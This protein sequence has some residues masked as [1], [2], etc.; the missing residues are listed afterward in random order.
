MKGSRIR[1]KCFKIKDNNLKEVSDMPGKDGKGPS[2][3]RQRAGDG[4]GRGQGGGS[5]PGPGGNCVC[6]NCGEKI[7]HQQGVPCYGKQ[8]PK[9]GKAMVRE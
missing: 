9:C 6:P 2:G 3:Q 7:P 4:S 5:T 8:C 1:V